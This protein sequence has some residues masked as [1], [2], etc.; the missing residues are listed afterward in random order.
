MRLY[1]S[2]FD[3]GDRPEELVALCDSGRRAAIIVNALDHLPEGRAVWLKKQTDKLVGLGF[4]VVELD[5]R[6]FF[7]AS[8]ELERF[9]SDIDVGPPK[10]RQALH[11]FRISPGCGST[12]IP[13]TSRW[14][15]VPLR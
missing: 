3:L 10:A 15:R 13:D 11:P 7:E 4:K 9:L 14:H 12:Q 8:N 5:L 1:L 6:S 2:S